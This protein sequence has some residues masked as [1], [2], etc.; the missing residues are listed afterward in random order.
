MNDV[1]IMVTTLLFNSS[2][3]NQISKYDDYVLLVFVNPGKT[4]EI[5][6]EPYNNNAIL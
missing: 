6:R 5:K 3:G 4:S 2:G 1:I